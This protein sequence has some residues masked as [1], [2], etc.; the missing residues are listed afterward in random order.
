M[1]F[2]DN[3]FPIPPIQRRDRKAADPWFDQHV[4][5]PI[6]ER[7]NRCL[8]DQELVCLTQECDSRSLV[9]RMPGLLDQL[10]IGLVR[11]PGKLSL[12]RGWQNIDGIGAIGK[13][14]QE[15]QVGRIVV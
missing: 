4:L 7:D 9:E 14:S 8:V 2:N 12:E 6:K 11:P 5:P 10:I 1:C 15:V 13:A 3:V